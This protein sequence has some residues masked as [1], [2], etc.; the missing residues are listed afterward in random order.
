MTNLDHLHSLI[1]HGAT[2][3]EGPGGRPLTEQ[4]YQDELSWMRGYPAVTAVTYDICLPGIDRT[5]ALAIWADG[6]IDSGS[7]ENVSRI[8]NHR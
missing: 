4:F 8:V 7:P 5:M 6:H 2:L 1:A 3:G